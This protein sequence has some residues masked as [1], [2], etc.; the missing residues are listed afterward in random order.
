MISRCPWQLVCAA[1]NFVKISCWV[2]WFLRFLQEEIF[3]CLFCFIWIESRFPLDYHSVILIRSLFI[4][5]AG[6]KGLRTV[7]ERDALSSSNYPNDSKFPDRLFVYTNKSK[8]LSIE[9]FENPVKIGD[10]VR[11]GH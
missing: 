2:V 8:D 10:K 9:P 3:Q 11:T 7:E 5:S 1:A 6:S 4:I